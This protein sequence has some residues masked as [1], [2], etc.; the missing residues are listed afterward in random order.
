MNTKL[1][2]KQ[3]LEDSCLGIVKKN[4][5]YGF[6]FDF[7]KRTSIDQRSPSSN[8]HPYLSAKKYCLNMAIGL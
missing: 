4:V 1:S 7:A 5:I 2:E 3:L 6:F 8:C